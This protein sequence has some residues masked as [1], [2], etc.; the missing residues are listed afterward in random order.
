MP[1]AAVR[2]ANRAYQDARQAARLARRNYDC[3]RA[4]RGTWTRTL[5]N[6]RNEW[7]LLEITRVGALVTLAEAEDAEL[8]GRLG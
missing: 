6:A 3:R 2:A 1:T 8:I 7:G 5:D 4:Q